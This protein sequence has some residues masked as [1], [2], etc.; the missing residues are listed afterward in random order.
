MARI[1]SDYAHL[2]TGMD[3]VLA[4][5]EKDFTLVDDVGTKALAEVDTVAAIAKR[6]TV[7]FKKTILA[8][9]Y[10]LIMR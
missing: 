1:P 9:D 2:A 6:A 7:F 8:V 3:A 10:I 5:P 4:A